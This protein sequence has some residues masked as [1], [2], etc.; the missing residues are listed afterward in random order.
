MELKKSSFYTLPPQPQLNQS[1]EYRK[2]FIS[3]MQL[4][5]QGSKQARENKEKI[6]EMK[7][8]KKASISVEA[9]KL[10]NK[11]LLKR[12]AFILTQKLNYGRLNRQRISPWFQ[13][14]SA[15]L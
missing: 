12:S 10:K 4:G 1:R 6:I 13:Q 15:N 7:G 2:P 8:P 11:E 9:G 3:R 14:L 5:I